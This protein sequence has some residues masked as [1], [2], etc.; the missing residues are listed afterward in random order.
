MWKG[1]R[2]EKMKFFQSIFCLTV[3]S[4]ALS[5]C[6]K[7]VP[8]PELL[9]PIYKDLKATFEKQKHL[10]EE[11]RKTLES[12]RRALEK[13]EA[14][15]IHRKILSK[16]YSISLQTIQKLEETS[17]FYEIRVERRKFTDRMTYKLA[18]EAGKPWPDP[19]EYSDYLVNKR[20]NEASRQWAERVPRLNDRYP[21]SHGSK[22]KEKKHESGE[23][24]NSEH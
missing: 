14:R 23:P 15:D 5:G 3:L 22:K 19:K 6:Q 8:E 7:G 11:E 16:D 9:D 4:F 24:G 1:A 21:S 13:T 20:L 18:L 10:L 17:R 2:L 12:T